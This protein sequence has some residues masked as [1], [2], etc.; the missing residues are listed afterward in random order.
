[1]NIFLCMAFLGLTA[2]AAQAQT[3]DSLALEEVVVTGTRNAVDVR[4]LPMTVS[5]IGRDITDD[6]IREMTRKCSRDYKETCGAF[7]VLT[8]EDMEA[9]YKMAR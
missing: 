1:M 9:I 4:H 6:E 3:A 5:V 8:A 2:M 7:K